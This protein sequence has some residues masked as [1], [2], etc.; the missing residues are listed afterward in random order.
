MNHPPFD[1]IWYL[2]TYPDVAEAVRKQLLPS[3][4]VHY[5]RLGRAQGRLP[6][7]FD[8]NFYS[9]RYP[10]V[11]GELARAATASA[12]DHYRAR[13]LARGYLPAPSAARAPNAHAP[14]SVHGGL[15]IDAPDAVDRVAG[16]HEIGMIT[17]EEAE[18]LL[19]FIANGYMILPKAVPNRLLDAAEAALDLAYGGGAPSLLFECHAVSPHPLS[20]QPEIRSHAAKALD[21]HAH[22]AAIRDLILSA[23]LVRYLSLLFECRP[24]A[25]QTLTFL[26]G[27]GQ[28]GHQDSAYVAYSLPRDFAASWIALEDVTP[29]AGELFYYPGS[30]RFPE[31]SY[32]GFKSVWEAQRSGVPPEDLDRLLSGHIRQ[33]ETQIA[34]RNVARGQ[35]MARRGD[36]LIWHA[37]LVHGGM[38]VSP[39]RTR[40]SVV[41][42]YCPRFNV[43]IYAEASPRPMRPHGDG[44][45]MSSYY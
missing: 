12:Y 23:T 24:L 41:T 13:G 25:S 1:E 5:E 22:S 10:L 34:A 14:R 32:G 31:F 35:F 29:G 11:R 9:S 36:V 33:I 38:P 40:K 4:L 8:E 43:P 6:C 16:R 45:T 19:F 20:W 37:D 30:H 2:E 39:D 42:H 7:P 15:W 44:F 17:S 27:S 28:E 21:F 3:G 26:R 18:R